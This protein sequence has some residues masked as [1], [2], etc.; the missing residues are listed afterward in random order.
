MSIYKNI[1]KV[2]AG[3]ITTDQRHN[4][5]K[6]TQR[7]AE[8]V[9]TV[10]AAI[11]KDRRLTIS[12]LTAAT[13]ATTTTVFRVLTEDLGLVKKSALWVPKILSA[14]QKMER[15]CIS[16]QFIAT[17]RRWSKSMLDCIVTIDETMVAYHTPETKRQSMQWLPKGQPGPIKAK[18]Q[19]SRTKQMVL[20]FFDN[21]DLIYVY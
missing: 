10:E 11:S 14:D 4:N 15:V 7:T 12:E 1:K 21:K 16:K 9:A 20:A 6:K 3:K 19:A 2:T 8:L 18:V 5:A 17:V 13:G